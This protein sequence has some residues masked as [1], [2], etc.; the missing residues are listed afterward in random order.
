[1]KCLWCIFHLTPSLKP[2]AV[3]LQTK[4]GRDQIAQLWMWNWRE[5]SNGISIIFKGRCH[6]HC[7]GGHSEQSCGIKWKFTIFHFLNL[8]TFTIFT[9]F[10]F[11]NTLLAL[12]VSSLLCPAAKNPKSLII[13]EGRDEIHQNNSEITVK[14]CHRV[15]FLNNSTTVTLFLIFK[16]KIGVNSPLY[17]HSKFAWL[18]QVWFL[19][20]FQ[21]KCGLNT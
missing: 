14:I 15:Y 3:I 19:P 16:N 4:S 17:L 5:I 7:G 2:E 8:Y 6:F 10:H 12:V 9:I 11:I 13:K 1:M 21:L 18:C 20:H